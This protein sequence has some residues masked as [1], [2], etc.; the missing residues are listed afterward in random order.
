MTLKTEVMMLSQ[1]IDL[2]RNKLHFQVYFRFSL[3]D[4]LG[5][6]LQ[7]GVKLTYFPDEAAVCGSREDFLFQSHVP[8]VR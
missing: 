5:L 3:D 7:T 4:V 6:F 1:F 8:V 2:N